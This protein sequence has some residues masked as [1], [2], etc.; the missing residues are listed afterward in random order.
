MAEPLT[1]E[2]R[3]ALAAELALGVL[4][5]EDRAQALRLQ[6]ADPEFAAEVA[7]WA[8]R[9]CELHAGFDEAPPRDLWNAIEQRLQGPSIVALEAR[10]RRWRWSAFGAGLIAASFAVALLVRPVPAP[11][12]LPPA[13]S[14]VAQLGD[15]ANGAMLAANY[16]P[17]T[18]S[19]RI[20]AAALPAS[21]LSPELW[22]IPAD[23]VP[24]SL[25][26][27]GARGVTELNVAQQH[28]ALLHEGATLA[29]TFEPAQ[30]APHA[31]PSSQPVAAGK[32]SLI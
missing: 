6:L 23:G 12:S 28:R 26:L 31:R 13:Q 21:K 10:V 22:I 25:G 2:E 9:L 14:I 19:L 1:P 15:A 18:G 11:M 24:R 3:D 16:D 5:G 32:I 20:R 27:L 7:A 17:A 4:E 8:Q 29:V 30:G